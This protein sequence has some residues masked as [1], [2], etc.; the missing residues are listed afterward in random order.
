MIAMHDLTVGVFEHT[1]I[2]SVM[3]TDKGLNT[4]R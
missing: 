4:R 1:E 3:D 2:N